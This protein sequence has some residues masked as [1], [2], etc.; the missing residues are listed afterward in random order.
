[1]T[2]VEE[3]FCKNTLKG[4]E[5]KEVGGI[6][7]CVTGCREKYPRGCFIKSIVGREVLECEPIKQRVIVNT[8]K[9]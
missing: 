7:I 1:M 9:G 4:V 8:S 2:K 6:S 3:F 5:V